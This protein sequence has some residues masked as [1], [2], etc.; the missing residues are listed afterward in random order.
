MAY[1]TI[2]VLICM[3]V[4]VGFGLFF[5]YMKKTMWSGMAAVL[6]LTSMTVQIYFVANNLINRIDGISGTLS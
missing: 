1:I 3:M 5:S 6:F 4:L 2:N